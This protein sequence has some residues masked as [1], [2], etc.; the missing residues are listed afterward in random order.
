M[1]SFLRKCFVSCIAL[2]F[3]KLTKLAGLSGNHKNKQPRKGHRDFL[4]RRHAA[5]KTFHMQRKPCDSQ[6][7]QVSLKT[8]LSQKFQYKYVEQIILRPIY[9]TCDFIVT[10]QRIQHPPTLLISYWDL[11]LYL[12]CPMVNKLSKSGSFVVNVTCN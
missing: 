6:I 11:F 1:K 9:I 4:A 3:V 10:V 2:S 12:S 5:F 8:V 7:C